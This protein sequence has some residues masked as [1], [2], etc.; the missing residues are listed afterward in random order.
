MSKNL[1]IIFNNQ[2]DIATL[3]ATSEA[4]PIEHT[5]RSGRSYAW[6]SADVAPQIITASIPPTYLSALV[7]LQHNISLTGSVR[8]EL[9]LS[10]SVVCD[11]GRKMP[12]EAKPLGEWVV[13]VDAWAV[14]DLSELPSRQYVHWMDRLELCDSYRITIEDAANP[15]GFI[16][17]G[18]IFSGQY[19]SPEYNPVYGLSFELDEFTE[20]VRTESGSSRSVGEGST[21]TVSFD[22]DFLNKNGME[23]LAL[24][25]VGAGKR[26]EVYLNVYPEQGGITE[27]IHAFSAKRRSNFAQQHNFFNNWASSMTFEES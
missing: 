6:R 14:S 20:L 22:L 19:Y 26:A 25:L 13:G 9:L 8:V 3:S 4:L 16:Q 21:R 2:H 23:E 12:S 10:G 7:L 18:R 24:A 11:S 15:L 5:Q 27:A 1:R 17:L